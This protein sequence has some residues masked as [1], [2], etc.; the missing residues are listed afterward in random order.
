MHRSGATRLPKLGAAPAEHPSASLREEC[1]PV[2]WKAVRASLTVDRSVG[3]V[4]WCTPGTA[5]ALQATRTF[6]DG[7]LKI[8]DAK[9]NDPNEHASS[10]LSP[11]LHFGQLSAQRMAL[12]VKT[13]NSKHN[14]SGAPPPP[15][16]AVTRA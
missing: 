1:K 12:I 6:C 8:F 10:D 4:D 9:R 16:R 15:T 5:A 11:Y 13:Y 14:E 3:E 7:R 2:D